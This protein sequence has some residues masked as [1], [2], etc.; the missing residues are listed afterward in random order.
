MVRQI[1]YIHGEEQ[2]YLFTM[3]SKSK[4]NPDTTY[5][6]L[7]QPKTH[8][9]TPKKPLHSCSLSSLNTQKEQRGF[10]A[11]SLLWTLFQRLD[12]VKF[13]LSH[14]QARPFVLG[15]FLFVFSIFW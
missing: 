14:L 4:Y 10:S 6:N 15:L 1:A 5:P 11:T 9:S 12:S 2:Q 8:S 7:S 3:T 13:S